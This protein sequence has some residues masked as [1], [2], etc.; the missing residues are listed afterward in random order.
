MFIRDFKISVVV[1]S[2][3][4]KKKDKSFLKAA[5]TRCPSPCCPSLLPLSPDLVLAPVSIA[6]RVTLRVHGVSQG[7]IS[8]TL[9]FPPGR[10]SFVSEAEIY[11]LNVAF[12]FPK[13][14]VLYF[15]FCYF[16][17]KRRRERQ[18]CVCEGSQATP[19]L[20]SHQETGREKSGA[21]TVLAW[22]RTQ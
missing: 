5:K 9:C 20:H 21:H 10:K 7:H 15:V 11:S 13:T 17:K 8:G 22:G 19:Q 1:F 6:G 12:V 14:L 4:M 2:F 18:G 3:Q 16:Q